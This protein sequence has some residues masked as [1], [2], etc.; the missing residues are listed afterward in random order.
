MCA[1]R[2]DGDWQLVPAAVDGEHGTARTLRLVKHQAREL[3]K[4]G[5]I[6]IG[7]IPPAIVAMAYAMDTSAIA[8]RTWS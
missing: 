6:P 1:R 2:S 7:H 8:A 4:V 5:I 3:A